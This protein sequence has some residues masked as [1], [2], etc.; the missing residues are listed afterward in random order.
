MKT[1]R[2]SIVGILFS[3]VLWIACE[4]LLPDKVLNIV[5]VVVASVMLTGLVLVAY[6]TV[7]RNKWG[8]NFHQV[9]CPCCHAP[10]PKVRKPKSRR[11]M[12]WGG[13]TCDKCGCEID[14]WGNQITTGFL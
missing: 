4:F 6:G 11:E 2:F 8:I 12:L 9:N 10:I 3:L 14:K 5:F 1:G 13:A 7:M